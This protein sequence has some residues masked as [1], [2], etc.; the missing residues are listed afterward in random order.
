MK[1]GNSRI[2]DRSQCFPIYLEAYC[3][4]DENRGEFIYI[5]ISL[6]QLMKLDRKIC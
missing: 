2:Y 1:E 6:P 4:D 3:Q 5:E